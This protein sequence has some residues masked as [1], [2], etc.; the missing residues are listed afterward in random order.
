M[1]TVTISKFVTD[2]ASI[3]VKAGKL[4]ETLATMMQAAKD[5]KA[6]KTELYAA[7]KAKGDMAYATVRQLYSRTLKSLGW[8]STETRGKTAKASSKAKTASTQAPKE[9]TGGM[10]DALAI[11]RV[12]ELASAFLLDDADKATFSRLLAAIDHNRKKATT[13]K[14]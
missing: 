1:T 2:V 9:K 14:K 5:Q 8:A 10:S 11:A 6:F 12:G 7:A 3:A 13:S 4:Q